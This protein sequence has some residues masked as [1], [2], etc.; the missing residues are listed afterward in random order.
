MQRDPRI[1]CVSLR[2]APHKNYC[3][4]RGWNSY[5]PSVRGGVFSFRKRRPWLQHLKHVFVKWATRDPRKLRNFGDWRV[6][7]SLDGN[8]FERERFCKFCSKLPP[9]D[10]VTE[11]EPLLMRH[12][13]E[14]DGPLLG[15]L[16]DRE[17]VINLVMNNVDSLG[18]RYPHPGFSTAEMNAMYLAGRRLDWSPYALKSFAACHIEVSP[19]YLP[20]SQSS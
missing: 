16:Y 1:A 12:E 18:A 9:F 15:T 13:Q 19:R 2:L 4:P 14:W 17:R 5:V 8:V 20:N 3:H 6:T 10:Y 11:V 7:F